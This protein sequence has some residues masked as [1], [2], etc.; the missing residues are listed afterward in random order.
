MTFFHRTRTLANKLF[1]PLGLAI[2]RVEPQAWFCSKVMTTTVGRFSIQVPAINPI[3]THYSRHPDYMGQLGRLTS[4]LKKKYPRLAAIDIG[5][6]VGDTACIIKSA[7]DIPLL[8]IEGDGF[9][10]GFLEKNI[11]Q[12]QNTAA[13]NFFLGEKTGGI[14]AAFEKSGWNA[15]IKP[16]KNP[17]SKKINILSLDDFLAKQP[18]VENFKLL[19]IDTEG[20]D[21]SI[22]RGGAKFI[23]QVHPIITFEYNRENMDAIGENGLTTLSMLAGFGY[24]HAIFHDANGR[25]MSSIKLSDQNL[26]TDLH[27]YADGRKGGI[28]YY[29]ITVFSEA[30]SDVA[31]MFAEQERSFRRQGCQVNNQAGS[32]SEN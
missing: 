15:T 14:T 31:Y 9:T 24:S 27:E 11:R 12:F 19:K 8:C 5:A 20:F 2:V 23:Q 25:F 4:L 32:G 17:S 30:D 1:G 29:D 28:Y 22:I 21:C 13:H 7:A 18:G 6:N 26:I 3:S 16:G 10:F